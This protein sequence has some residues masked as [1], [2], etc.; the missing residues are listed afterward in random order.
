MTLSPPLFKVAISQKG[1]LIVEIQVVRDIVFASCIL[2]FV[3]FSTD[4]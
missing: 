3:L 4:V 1:V 2:T